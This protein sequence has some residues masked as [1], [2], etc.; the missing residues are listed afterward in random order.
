MQNTKEKLQ[1]I[2]NLTAIEDSQRIDTNEEGE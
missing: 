2:D 1:T